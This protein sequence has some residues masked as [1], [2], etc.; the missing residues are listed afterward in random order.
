MLAVGPTP[1]VR[2]WGGAS[3]VLPLWADADGRLVLA[4]AVGPALVYGA[5]AYACG[6][7]AVRAT[8]VGATAPPALAPARDKVMWSA[9]SLSLPVGQP[10]HPPSSQLINADHH[11]HCTTTAPVTSVFSS[12]DSLTRLRLSNRTAPCQVALTTS[13]CDARSSHKATAVCDDDAN[14]VAN[15]LLSSH[16]CW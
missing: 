13:L 4:A 10:M 9:V 15:P 3:M 16:L 5:V 12:P 8:A 2:G 7:T 11:H 14:A 1:V 6:P